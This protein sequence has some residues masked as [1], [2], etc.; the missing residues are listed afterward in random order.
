[1]NNLKSTGTA[2]MVGQ[3]VV[4]SRVNLLDAGTVRF[5]HSAS[6]NPCGMVWNVI[7]K[8]RRQLCGLVGEEYVAIKFSLDNG[9]SFA[10]Y[11][12]ELDPRLAG[13]AGHNTAGS[14]V[15][16]SKR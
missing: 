2:L 6:S 8:V 4:S 12:F 10:D 13:Q 16:N 11:T 5:L 15:T 7:N 14:N 3:T 1:M 9:N